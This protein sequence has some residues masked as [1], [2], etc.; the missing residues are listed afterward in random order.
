M[1]AALIC[2]SEKSQSGAIAS[3]LFDV[4]GDK[5][6]PNSKSS[7]PRPR[8]RGT[9]YTSD[10][11][12]KVDLNSAKDSARYFHLLSD[13]DLLELHPTA[14]VIVQQASEIVLDWYRQY[15]MCF[16]DSRTLSCDEFTRAFKEAL[17]RSQSA[18]L[19]GDIDTYSVEVNR[20]GE[21]LAAR[22]VPLVEVIPLLQLFK[23]SVHRVLVRHWA[24]LERLTTAFAKLTH[25][26]TILIVSAYSGAT[27]AQS[28]VA[29]D[30]PAAH[31]A[32]FHGLVGATPGMR[33]L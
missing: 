14:E 6:D 20:L 9:S 11:Q 24:G 10:T 3:F 26:E 17:Q 22:R 23:D 16:G 12:N 4:P 33:Q 25:L 19:G 5:Q 18:L 15:V 27:G 31:E 1:D 13:R 2:D 28:S 32:R 30:L 29:A 7:T 21:L 8:W